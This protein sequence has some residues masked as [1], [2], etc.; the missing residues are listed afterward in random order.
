MPSEHGLKV[1]LEV[2]QGDANSY[3]CWAAAAMSAKKTLDPPVDETDPDGKEVAFAKDF[4]DHARWQGCEGPANTPARYWDRTVKV[5]CLNRVLQHA[6][7]S[8]GGVGPNGL[9]WAELVQALD[10]G[11][12]MLCAPGGAGSSHVVCIWHAQ[13][14][15]TADEAVITVFDPKNSSSDVSFEGYDGT[16]AFKAGV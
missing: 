3:T 13:D 14:A 8:K 16:P 7:I 12:V 1:L 5:T 4:W 10:A 6:A 2:P 9:Q 15:T 11:Q